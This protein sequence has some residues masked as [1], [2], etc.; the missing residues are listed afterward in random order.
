M[1]FLNKPKRTKSEKQERGLA[2]R[3]GGKVTPGSGSGS[4]KGD[5]HTRSDIRGE[6]GRVYEEMVEAKT[7]SKTQYTLKL[8]DLQKLERE[9]HARGKK[10]VFILRVNDDATITLF[11]SE[12]V[13][14]PI[15]MYEDLT[16]RLR[17]E[18]E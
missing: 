3:L 15:S 7:T 12:Y 10:P 13:V 14:I 4:A 8:R 18:T 1:S 16:R 17:E 6:D 5:V 9:A 2:K 11:E